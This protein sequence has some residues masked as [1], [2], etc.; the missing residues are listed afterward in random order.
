M[1][2]NEK[3]QKLLGITPEKQKILDVLAAEISLNVSRVA[4]AAD[5][6]RT[7]AAFLLRHLETQGLVAKVKI[8]NHFEWKSKEA[9]DIARIFKSLIRQFSGRGE[10]SHLSSGPLKVRYAE[11]ENAILNEI[12]TTFQK[13][14]G[15]RLYLI[16]CAHSAAFQ[17]RKLED[18][19]FRDF[20]FAI[21]VFT[22]KFKVVSEAVAPES[23]LKIF[24]T[25]K[26]EERESHFGRPMITYF[27]PEHL[28]SF[29]S[30]IILAGKTIMILDYQSMRGLILENE[31]INKIFMNMFELMKFH[32]R[33]I[34]LNDYLKR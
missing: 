1:N 26:K 19:K 20:V 32:S 22:K 30:D 7:S 15:H 33:K 18:P 13:H 2:L 28:L 17:A 16:Q 31:L 34:N 23:V 8:G 29:E 21:H 11:G 3:Q 12:K 24:N 4:K 9:G 5:I 25:L 27:I 14:G 6:P 10:T